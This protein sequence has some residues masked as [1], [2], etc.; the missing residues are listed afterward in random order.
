MSGRPRIRWHKMAKLAL[1]GFG[2]LA[3]FMGL[4]SLTRRPE[5]PPLEPDIGF[6]HVATPPRAA[7]SGTRS[8]RGPRQGAKRLARERQRPP[9][10][11]PRSLRSPTRPEPEPPSAASPISGDSAPA[12]VNTPTPTTAAAPLPP[13]P[14]PAAQAP[15]PR[16]AIES[17]FGFER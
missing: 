10:R 1:A 6:A 13:P 17:E 11:R 3:L 15:E 2:C 16:A 14:P 5:P 12:P 4:P 9:D 7:P 8:G